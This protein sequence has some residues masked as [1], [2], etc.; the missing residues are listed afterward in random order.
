MGTIRGKYKIK[1]ENLI[2]LKAY[3]NGNIDKYQ[4]KR[5]IPKSFKKN[6]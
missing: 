3:I 2:K 1:E 6:N 4:D 5:Y